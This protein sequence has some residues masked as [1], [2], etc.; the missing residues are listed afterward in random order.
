MSNGRRESNPVLNAAELR[1]AAAERCEP[2]SHANSFR[3]VR[4]A[5]NAVPLCAD[6]WS[7]RWR[8]KTPNR[9][10]RLNSSHPQLSS[11]IYDVQQ[12][13]TDVHGSFLQ[14]LLSK[15][16]HSSTSAPVFPLPPNSTE[17]TTRSQGRSRGGRLGNSS[18]GRILTPRRSTAYVTLC[19][20]LQQAP[21]PAQRR[22]RRRRLGRRQRPA[23]AQP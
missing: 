20:A 10:A 9:V 6:G 1:A 17:R 2:P 21:D 8:F 4:L 7:E 18:H 14:A 23:R 15:N 11:S 12:F 3:T 16:L 5:V 19:P 22:P 13:L